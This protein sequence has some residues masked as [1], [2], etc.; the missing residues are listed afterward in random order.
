MLPEEMWWLRAKGCEIRTRDGAPVGVARDPE[1]AKV[2]ARV[3]D[4]LDDLYGRSIEAR[5]RASRPARR[6]AA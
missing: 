1:L 4:T 6:A 3:P 5:I 2:I